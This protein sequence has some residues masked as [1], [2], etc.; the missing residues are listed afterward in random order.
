MWVPVRRG[1]RV[2]IKGSWV[3]IIKN[4]TMYLRRSD[5]LHDS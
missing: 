5:D 1:D 4:T 3:H 2:W